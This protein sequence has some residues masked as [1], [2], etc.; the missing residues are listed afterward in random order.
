MLFNL[1]R[2]DRYYIIIQTRNVLN[3][4]AFFRNIDLGATYVALSVA[5]SNLC[6][7]FILNL[8]RITH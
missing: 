2:M 3:S 5:G 4:S 8:R 7:A 1:L 6:D